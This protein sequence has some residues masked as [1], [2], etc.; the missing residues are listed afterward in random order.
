[1]LALYGPEA[2]G[3]V[4]QSQFESFSFADLKDFLL[5][6]PLLPPPS[7]AITAT[8]TPEE[9]TGAAEGETPT[10]IPTP[11]TPPAFF[12]QTALAGA[13]WV[14]FAMLDRD[15]AFD[16]ADALNLFLAQRPDIARNSRVIVFA[17]NAPYYLDATQISQL[18]AYYGVY[19][20]TDAFIDA[21]VR[22]LF[23]EAPLQG[24]SPVSIEGIRYDLKQITK[25]EANQVIE[26]YIID[27]GIP[28][29][30]P[31]EEPLEA[32][33]GAT[34]R[35]QTGIIIDGNGNPVPDGTIVQFI[36]QDRLEGFVNV[37][38]ERPTVKG[39]ANLDYLLE[40]RSGN[41]RI[42]AAAGV[43]TSS[44]EIDIVIGENA[45]VSVSTTTPTPT[46]TSTPT[47]TPTSTL[48]PTITPS[49]MPSRTPTATPTISPIE[50]ESEPALLSINSTGQMLLAFGVGLMITGYAGFAF[51]QN[52]NDG[53]SET[54]R[55][56]LWGLIGALLSYIYFSLGLPGT[57][58][59]EP[60]GYWAGLVTT[61]AG[62]LFGLLFYRLTRNKVT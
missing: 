13:D 53:L 18:T 31:S 59:I 43:A 56:V 30:P 40:A 7:P 17:H 57:A 37:I 39:V 50:A 21:A 47:R 33:P 14:I 27:E 20:K 41:F 48:T 3:Q 5:S 60:L 34:L 44:Q 62:G 61:T 11:T 55:C 19:S 25:P 9:G 29:S 38:E 54:L 46:P 1:M 58:W 8:L 2:S 6:E 49:P 24:R 42:T 28:K 36:Q 22:G 45:I 15:P 10:P 32:V 4:Q 35:L 52:E 12:V 23:L 16:S 26:L 51:G